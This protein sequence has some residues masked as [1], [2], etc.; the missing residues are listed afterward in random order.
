MIKVV[1]KEEATEERHGKQGKCRR[2]GVLGEEAL[3]L[4]RRTKITLIQRGRRE[5]QSFED[6]VV[7]NKGLA[8]TGQR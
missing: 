7:G 5:R 8:Q 6:R 4:H 2:V 1:Q 3:R